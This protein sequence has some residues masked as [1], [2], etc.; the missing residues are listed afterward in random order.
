MLAARPAWLESLGVRLSI[1]G[2]HWRLERTER[3]NVQ[4]YAGHGETGATEASVRGRWVIGC[5]SGTIR[6]P[7][8]LR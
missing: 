2:R 3:I 4:K 7:E 1:D 5:Q 6:L 8:S